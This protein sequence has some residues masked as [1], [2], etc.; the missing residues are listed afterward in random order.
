MTINV[1]REKSVLIEKVWFDEALEE[2]HCV[3]VL[4]FIERTQP[5]QG[6]QFDEFHTTVIDLK[7]IVT[8]IGKIS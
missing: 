1:F 2:K 4:H 6:I 5:I 8:T 7:L 3:D